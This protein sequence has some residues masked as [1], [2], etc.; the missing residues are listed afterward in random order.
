MSKDIKVHE[1]LNSK[2]VENTIHPTQQIN[3]INEMIASC[4]GD[5]P[6]RICNYVEK[7]PC[8]C[9]VGCEN[10]TIKERKYV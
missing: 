4:G 1:F 3:T 5:I 9:C 2:E 7:C 6:S 8:T 10:N